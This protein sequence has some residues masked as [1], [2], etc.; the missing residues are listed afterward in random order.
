M[1]SDDLAPGLSLL[2]GPSIVVLEVIEAFLSEYTSELRRLPSGPPQLLQGHDSSLAGPA[3][4]ASPRHPSQLSTD[5]GGKT[6]SQKEVSSLWGRLLTPTCRRDTPWIQT[7]LKRAS[8]IMQTNPF[9]ARENRALERSGQL[10]Q[11]A[12]L[13]GGWSGPAFS[14]PPD[15]WIMAG[16][17]ACKVRGRK[18]S[19]PSGSFSDLACS[20]AVG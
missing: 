6:A 15:A 10:G 16:S 12:R 8:E 7:E 20:R 11:L 2:W 13:V 1:L 17:V 9:Y 3:I 4:R 5:R 18:D 14:G 19:A